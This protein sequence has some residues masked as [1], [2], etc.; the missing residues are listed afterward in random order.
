M[1]KITHDKKGTKFP[2]FKHLQITEFIVALIKS[3]DYVVNK[4]G[5]V[6]QSPIKLIPD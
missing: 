1:N 2:N 5:P 3:S 6:I 4:L